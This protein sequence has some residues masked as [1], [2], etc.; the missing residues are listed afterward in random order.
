MK[1]I[2]IIEERLTSD[3][4]QE[5]L[6]DSDQVSLSYRG[7]IVY[8]S[9]KGDNYLSL[10]LSSP[11]TK[12]ELSSRCIEAYREAYQLTDDSIDAFDP[13]RLLAVYNL[14]NVYVV[15]LGDYSH[16][17]ELAED[18]FNLAN[19]HTNTN[20]VPLAEELLQR[21]RDDFMIYERQLTLEELEAAEEARIAI[22]EAK[23]EEQDPDLKQEEALKKLDDRPS[24]EED[25]FIILSDGTIRKKFISK[26]ATA[27]TVRLKSQVF[28][29]VPVPMEAI[30]SARD[31]L[32]ALDRIFRA[33]VRG[34]AL[35]GH[36]ETGLSVSLAGSK[37]SLGSFLLRGH[38]SPKLYHMQ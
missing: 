5:D 34:N 26:Y 23:L 18:A 22:E 11:E 16:S 38:L 8:L 15:L 13:L 24:E 14:C 27:V 19:R 28:L 35:P 3:N 33:Y 29:P 37:I 21:L 31:V 9:V 20:K 7:R 36:Q 17:K 25:Q 30:V 1:A 2:D 6:D 12:D 4:S 10:A 32:L